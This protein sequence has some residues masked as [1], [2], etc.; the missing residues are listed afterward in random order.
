MSVALYP[1]PG[2]LPLQAAVQRLWTI[3]H[4]VRERAID[5]LAA[6]TALRPLRAHPNV[7]V[8]WL[9]S[10]TTE[11]VLAMFTDRLRREAAEMTVSEFAR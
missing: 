9:A 11:Q 8:A 1:T 5:L 2:P 3:R 4:L 6:D 10:Q 7:R